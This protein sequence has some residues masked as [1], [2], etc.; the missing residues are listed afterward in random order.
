MRDQKFA[1]LDFAHFILFNK[2]CYCPL[3][4]IASKF[5]INLFMDENI[6]IIVWNQNDTNERNVMKTHEFITF[7]EHPIIQYLMNSVD[8]LY[9]FNSFKF[10]NNYQKLLIKVF[11]NGNHKLLEYRF[12]Y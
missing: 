5:W 11:S 9:D 12:Y 3:H 8:T 10:T 2:L 4:N 1:R 7:T 6:D